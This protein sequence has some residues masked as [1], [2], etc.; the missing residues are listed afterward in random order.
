VGVG[1]L[2]GKQANRATKNLW[3]YQEA[4]NVEE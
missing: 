4:K 3:N 1:L 2:H